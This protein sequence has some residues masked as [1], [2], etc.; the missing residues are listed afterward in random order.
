MERKIR[1]V[2]EAFQKIDLKNVRLHATGL[3]TFCKLVENR[4]NNLPLGYSFGRDS[5]NTPILKIVTPNMMKIGRLNSRSLSGPIKF[6][7]GP[8]DYLKKVEET[9]NAFF[10]IWNIS[11]VPKLV[12]QPKWYRDATIEIKVGDIVYF[13]KVINELSDDW[14][15]GV[16]DSVVRSK[17]GVI[18][19]VSVKYHNHGDTAPKYT[20]RAVRT[21]VRLFNLDDNYFIE[22]LAKVEELINAIQ[23]KDVAM[24]RVDPVR[25]VRSSSGVYEVAA[26][27]VDADVVRDVLPADCD[28]CCDGHCHL[29]H[30]SGVKMADV[31]PFSSLMAANVI[32]HVYPE[33]E[34]DEV[35]GDLP[36]P[37]EKDALYAVLTALE[38]KFDLDV[39]QDDADTSL[40]H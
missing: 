7:V 18:R 40:S 3:Q 30:P 25:L 8:K 10:K 22:D 17:D 26:T 13:Q 34:D 24:P 38:T 15:V 9:Y 11:L 33:A 5:N 19:R 31:D 12:P 14:T 1:S 27:D 20:D 29:T 32:P 23:R 35:V 4:M 16:I 28:C 6:P 39:C 2:Q 37:G 21:I 36:L